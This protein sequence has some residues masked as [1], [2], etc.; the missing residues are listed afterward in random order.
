MADRPLRHRLE[1]EEREQIHALLEAL[2]DGIGADAI[3]LFDD[4]RA[5]LRPSGPT[6]PPNFWDAFGGLPCVSVDWERW[7]EELRA[8]RRAEAP[9]TCA[10]EHRLLGFLI[11]DRWALLLMASPTLIPGAAAIIASG[12]KVLSDRL[13]PPLARELLTDIRGQPEELDGPSPPLAGVPVWWVRKS[14]Q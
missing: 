2:R 3:G 12:V 5:E 8:T 13:P 9:C 6:D 10:T 7:Y 4:G 14:R 11:R 1:P